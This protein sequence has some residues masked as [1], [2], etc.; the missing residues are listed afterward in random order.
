MHLSSKFSNSVN[1]RLNLSTNNIKK[2]KLL[3][4][5]FGREGKSIFKWIT[6]LYLTA[7]SER[8][9]LGDKSADKGLSAV[10]SLDKI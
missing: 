3:F 7:V 9:L 6:R 5:G 8:M 2:S 10:I 4:T 1:T